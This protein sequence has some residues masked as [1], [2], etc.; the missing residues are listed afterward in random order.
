MAQG[1]LQLPTTG[2]VSGLQNN[3]DANAALAALATDIQGAAAPTA[4]S[5]GLASTAGVRWHDTTTNLHKVRDQA[6]STFIVKGAFDETNKLYTP[7][8]APVYGL[9]R[10]VV[11]QCAGAGGTS[12]TLK[13]DEFLGKTAAGGTALLGVNGNL[14]VNLANTGADG[15]DSGALAA[16]K[17]YRTY[18][19][20]K[21]ADGTVHTLS[22]LDSNAAPSPVPSGF[23]VLSVIAYCLSDSSGKILPFTQY[24][25]K[26]WYQTPVNIVSGVSSPASLTSQSVSSAVPVSA[27]V[28][29]VLAGGVT[30]ASAMVAIAGDAAGSGMQ[31]GLVAALAAASFAGFNGVAFFGGVPLLISQTIFWSTNGS[32]SNWGRISVVGFSF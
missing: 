7:V 1:L 10:N 19:L 17:L 32:V 16:N 15:L 24:D 20:Y 31:V 2:T 30:N 13:F 26:F 3:Q 9:G 21:V 18:L 12:F 8:V 28:V 29:D 25:R 11:A 6:D 22:T 5:T 27:K 23:T 14:T 4:A